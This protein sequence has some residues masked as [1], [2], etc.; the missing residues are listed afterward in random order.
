ML[1][2]PRHSLPLL[3]PSQAQKHV[4][5]NEALAR[6]DAV[7]QLVMASRSVATP[8]EVVTEG[9]VFAV[10]EGAMNAWTGQAGRI[11]IAVNGGWVFAR[12][13]T[14]WRAFIEDEWVVALHDG[15]GWVAPALAISAGGAA[16]GIS[17]HEIDHS[18]TAGSAS[19]IEAAIPSQVV[20]FGL[21]GR[22]LEQVGG[23]ASS[24]RI[25]VPGAVDRYGSGVGVS[26]GAWMRGLTGTP[27]AYYGPTDI[28]LTAEGGEFSG[29]GLL[30]IAVHYA[31]LGLPR[32][33]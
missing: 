25:G 10:P 6:L 32:A 31:T 15:E 2:T 3:A 16:F 27:L 26:E 24:F 13:T 17:V 29:S 14:G 22:V 20:V 23:T 12:P 5:V 4:T 9:M 7:T 18:F 30:R 11:A 28:V 33:I 1:E 19:T 8:P 21:T